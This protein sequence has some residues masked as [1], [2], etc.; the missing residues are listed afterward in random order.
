MNAKKAVRMIM[1]QKDVSTLDMANMLG[2][3]MQ[4]VCDRLSEGKSAN[5][6]VEKLN[7]FVSH[8]GYKIVLIPEETKLEPW[9]YEV[10]S[11]PT[12]KVK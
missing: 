8:L 12:R 9:W 7:E 3:N 2:S 6:S 10:D 5:L 11:V 1:V 4:K